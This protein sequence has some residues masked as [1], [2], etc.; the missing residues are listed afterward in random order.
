MS[1]PEHQVLKR[2][3]G[4]AVGAADGLGDGLL[5]GLGAVHDRTACAD[6]QAM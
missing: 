6:H 5:F 2:E 3:P 4:A 1:V